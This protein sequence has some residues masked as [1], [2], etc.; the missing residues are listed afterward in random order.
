MSGTKKNKDMISCFKKPIYASIIAWMIGGLISC[1]EQHDV[2]DEGI[3]T[4]KTCMLDFNVSCGDFDGLS[5][6]TA[7]STTWA[8]GDKIYFT[9]DNDAYGMATY[10]SDEW[11]VE[12]FGTLTENIEKNCKAVYFSNPKSTEEFQAVNLTHET[13]VYEDTLSTYKFD[14]SLLT[15]TANLQ[16]KTARLRFK[17]NYNDTIH[18]YGLKMNT[19]YSVYKGEYTDTIS[20]VQLVAKSDGYTPYNYGG[21]PDTITR[22]LNVATSKS[23]YS[24]TFDNT[25]MNE[26]QSGWLTIP[27]D[28]A[29]N[30]WREKMIFKVK[31]TEFAMMPVTEN[32][33]LSFLLGETEVTKGLYNALTDTVIVKSDYPKAFA[34]YGDCTAFLN[35]VNSNLGVKFSLPSKIQWEWA[36]KGGEKSQNYTYSGSNT[37]SEV[38]WYKD[39]SDN[40]VHEVAKLMPNE[41]GIYDMFGNLGE[42][43]SSYPTSYS[44]SY[45]Y[46]KSNFSNNE[47]T[48]T[49]Y[50]S[51]TSNV[52][53]RLK[54]S[55]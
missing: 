16:P 28:S 15:V 29:H 51:S 52:G 4:S 22:R 53:M 42:W 34:S 13:A 5:T 18:V 37:A 6:R 45:Y 43:T 11:M 33:H 9:F 49:T 30:A 1:S 21:F 36:Y 50:S 14:G 7:T 39:N 31:T 17:G 20:F 55:F 26:G 10:Q 40:K 8:E 35:I 41:L 3:V 38:G 2:L 19:R 44:S 54:L 32:G 47:T 46:Y 24:R 48:G 23:A 27:T 25:V 12:Y